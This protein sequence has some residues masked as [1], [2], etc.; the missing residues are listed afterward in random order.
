MWPKSVMCPSWCEMTYAV[1]LVI[2]SLFINSSFVEPNNIVK[3]KYTP[4][5]VGME[6]V[7]VDSWVMWSNI[8]LSFEPLTFQPMILKLKDPVTPEKLKRSKA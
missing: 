3:K 1:I 5:S 8:I 6:Q 7:E 4:D 2:L